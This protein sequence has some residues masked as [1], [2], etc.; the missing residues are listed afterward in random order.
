[1]LTLLFLLIFGAS[2][3]IIENQYVNEDGLKGSIVFYHTILILV[4]TVSSEIK[5]NNCSCSCN[6]F[7]DNLPL[8]KIED[9][10]PPI[11]NA[12]KRKIMIYKF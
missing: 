11:Q 10:T 8:N 6:C 4:F 9:P 3:F 5:N 2:A 1:M 7:N 12:P